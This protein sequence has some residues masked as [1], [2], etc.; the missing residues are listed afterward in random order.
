MNVH[1]TYKLDKSPTA[2]Q[3]LQTQI[4]KLGPRLHVF[5]PDMISLRGSIELAPKSGFRVGLNLR[6]PAGQMAAQASAESLHE[7]I[8]IVF[9]DLT[10][11]LRKHKEHLR[12]Q[13]RYPRV[14][15]VERHRIETQVRIRG[16]GC[17]R[18]AGEGFQ[19]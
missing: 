7:A 16:H 9:G 19:P 8:R 12:S 10:E 3:Y 1:F 11:Q 18:E 13:Y 6:L 14:R 17:G 4:D 5:N 2:E 15:G